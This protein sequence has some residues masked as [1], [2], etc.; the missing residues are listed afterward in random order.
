MIEKKILAIAS[1]KWFLARL[2]IIVSYPLAIMK[3]G[4]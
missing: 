1:T 3:S 4:I 2:P